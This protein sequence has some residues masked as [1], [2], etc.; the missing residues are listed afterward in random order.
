MS[1]L[2]SQ[3]ETFLRREA[4]DGSSFWIKSVNMRQSIVSL[5]RVVAT[6][7]GDVLVKQSIHQSN[8]LD[9]QP[10]DVARSILQLPLAYEN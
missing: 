5:H 9:Q 7:F 1:F 2:S 8:T 6:P 10:E 4:G 3:K